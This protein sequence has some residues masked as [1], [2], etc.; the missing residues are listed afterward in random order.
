MRFFSFLFLV[1]SF[2]NSISVCTS[3]A[4]VVHTGQFYVGATWTWS[5][6]EWNQGAA[7]FDAPYLFETYRVTEVKGPLVT[8]E[9]SSGDREDQKN[10]PHHK[11]VAN[12][13]ECL[14]F[15]ENPKLLRRFRIEFYTKSLDGG[16]TLLAPHYNALAF[17]EKFNCLSTPQTRHF[18][19][20]PVQGQTV[21]AFQWQDHWT[22]S[23]YALA[24]ES[25]LHG[26]MIRRHAR[27]I[28]IELVSLKYPPPVMLEPERKPDEEGSCRIFS[29]SF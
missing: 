1:F 21:A 18:D 2:T 15:G 6:S 19:R 3:A 11:F 8:V 27:K 28:L 20:F 7:D 14:E 5:Y 25:P 12:L 22:Q 9:M 4:D 23:W 10:S 16:W 29:V 13:Q 24:P 26:V 17:T